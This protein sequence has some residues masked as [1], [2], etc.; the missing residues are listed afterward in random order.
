MSESQEPEEPEECDIYFASNGSNTAPAIT[1]L[2]VLADGASYPN[3]YV[4][5]KK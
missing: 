2:S 4:V 1:N 3:L 5:S